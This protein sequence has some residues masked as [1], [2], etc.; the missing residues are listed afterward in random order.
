MLKPLTILHF[1]STEV[2]TDSL[3]DDPTATGEL[4][5]EVYGFLFGILYKDKPWVK[6]NELKAFHER[7]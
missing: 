3:R 4:T 2:V 1:E 7:K 5:T 6:E